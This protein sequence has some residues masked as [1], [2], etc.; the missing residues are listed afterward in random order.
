MSPMEKPLSSRRD[1]LKA[2][3]AAPLGLLAPVPA[4]AADGSGTIAEFLN[5]VDR[6]EGEVAE[7]LRAL[8]QARPSAR[9]FAT[10]V[11][12]DRARHQALRASLRAARGLSPRINSAAGQPDDLASLGAL[13]EVQKTLVYTHVEGL[14]LFF[15][16]P[17]AVDLLGKNMIDLARQLTVIDLWIDH[18]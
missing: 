6:L 7:R 18:A 1:L 2:L 12:A 8:V 15:D 3:A 9:A 16:D 5:T 11:G 13:R 10:S 4:R 14:P 17:K